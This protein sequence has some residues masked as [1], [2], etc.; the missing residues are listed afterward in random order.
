MQQTLLNLIIYGDYDEKAGTLSCNTCR[1]ETPYS[2]SIYGPLFPYNSKVFFVIH[3][4]E[5]EKKG[6]VKDFQLEITE[7]V[8]IW[9][10][11]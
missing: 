4:V 6:Q 2:V 9:K 7:L 5:K 10:R 11:D 1:G 3:H 8:A